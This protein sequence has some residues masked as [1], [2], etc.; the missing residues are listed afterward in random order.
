MV[1]NIIHIYKVC[2]RMGLWISH[3]SCLSRSC[4]L[5]IQIEWNSH[6]LH[7]SCHGHASRLPWMESCSAGK[8]TRGKERGHFLRRAHIHT[9]THVHLLYIFIQSV[10]SDFPLSYVIDGHFKLSLP[11]LCIHFHF[12]NGLP[13]HFDQSVEQYSLWADSKTKLNSL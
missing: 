8:K 13:L 1:I 3:H 6:T 7:Y 10:P 11:C 5:A 2:E 9:N 4:E 12:T